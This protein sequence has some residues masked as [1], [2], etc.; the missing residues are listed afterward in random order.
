MNSSYFSL[1]LF[2]TCG[3]ISQF[4]EEIEQISNQWKDN[5]KEKSEKILNRTLSVSKEVMA[6]TLHDATI[7][8]VD[9]IQKA[10]FYALEESRRLTERA[11]RISFFAMVSAGAAIFGLLCVLALFFFK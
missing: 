6:K 1:I 8:S 11:E 4:K 7:Q 2:Q 5:A 10:I 3:P 9:T